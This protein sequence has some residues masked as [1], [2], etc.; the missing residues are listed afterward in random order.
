MI[1][2]SNQRAERPSTK[3]PRPV[4][5]PGETVFT[6]TCGHNCGGRCVVNAHVRGRPDREDQHRSAQVDARAAA[7]ARVRA[8]LRPGRAREPPRPAAAI[9]CVGSGRAARDSSSGSRGTR[10]ST[11]SR[12][13]MRASA[14]PTAPAAILDCSRTGSLSMLHNA[15]HHR[16]APAAHVRR[17]H[18]A[19]VEHLGRGRGVRG[20]HDLRRQGGLQERRPRAHRLRQ[21]AAHRSCG[22]G[23]RAT[24]PS[25]PARCSTSSWPRST[26]MRIICV[27]PRRTRTSHD[28]ADE[29]VFIRPS[30]DAAALIAMAYVIASRGA[31]R[32]GVPA[33]ATCW[34]STRRTCRRARP[35]RASYRSYLLGLAD[36]VRKTPEWAA[37]ITGDTG[38]DDPSAGHRVRHDASRRR[39]TCGYAP[40]RTTS[41]RAVPPR[42]LRAVPR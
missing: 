30:T 32:P 41:R 10:R 23:A 39:C 7:A 40:G 38:R 1:S 36:G 5:A 22:A 8:R 12:G 2:W 24:A 21:L 25:A 13:Q 3:L 31:A 27:D 28:L 9:P 29:H 15:A 37:A 4:A 6:S 34:A 16:A 18:G 35:P 26:G 14:T 20:A 42:G 17:L 33:I 19:V 11:R